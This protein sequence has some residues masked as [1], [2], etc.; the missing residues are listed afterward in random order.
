MDMGTETIAT[1]NAAHIF[2]FSSLNMSSTLSKYSAEQYCWRLVKEN[3]DVGVKRRGEGSVRVSAGKS[4]PVC[5][6][7]RITGKVE[8]VVVVG[9]PPCGGGGE[10]GS[11]ARCRQKG[12]VRPLVPA[13]GADALLLWLIASTGVERLLVLGVVFVLKEVAAANEGSRGSWRCRA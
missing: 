5:L 10:V 6:G 1:V 11:A 8:E 7:L 3:P 12:D 2:S 13:A 9:R 4:L